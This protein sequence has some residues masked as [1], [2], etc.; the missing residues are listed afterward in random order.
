RCSRQKKAK[1]KSICPASATTLGFGSEV[2]CVPNTHCPARRRSLI[3]NPV[4]NSISSLVNKQPH[5]LIPAVRCQRGGGGG[6][7]GCRR[8]CL[9][10]REIV[11]RQRR[12]NLRHTPRANDRSRHRTMRRHPC[13][14]NGR[15]IPPPRLAEIDK[16][17]RGAPVGLLIIARLIKPV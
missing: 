7:R 14:G 12:F 15:R 1:S 5:L 3:S 13:D 17:P 2:T 6:R 9:R 8:D 11:R 16:A 10:H 4:I